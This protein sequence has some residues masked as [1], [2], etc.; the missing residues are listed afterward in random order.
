VQAAYDNVSYDGK[1]H[2]LTLLPLE[3]SDLRTVKK[4]AAQTLEK[5]GHD[6]L[7]ILMLN[8]ALS[9]AANEPGINGTKWSEQFV[10]NH[11]C[12]RKYLLSSCIND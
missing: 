11:L 6:K 9:K 7:D 3:L 5:L 8:A 1:K 12:T 10:V 2:S 4:F